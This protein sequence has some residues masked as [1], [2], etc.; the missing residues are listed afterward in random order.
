MSGDRVSSVPTPTPPPT[1]APDPGPACSYQ[2]RRSAPS[3]PQLPRWA[4]LPSS[5]SGKPYACQHRP[6]PTRP[7]TTCPP[8]V[9]QRRRGSTWVPASNSAQGGW[10][11][12]AR[13][14]TSQASGP[15]PVHVKLLPVHRLE[16]VVEGAG[17]GGALGSPP[18]AA[19]RSDTCR[20]A[21]LPIQ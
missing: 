17:W 3:G 16:T 10:D 8:F 9:G 7:G 5:V 2:G 1:I 15:P 6:S 13:P 4:H 21:E 14:L 18:L 19:P 12:V 11:Q 20:R